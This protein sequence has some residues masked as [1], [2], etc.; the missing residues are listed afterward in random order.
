[1]LWAMPRPTVLGPLL[2]TA[3]AALLLVLVAGC[4]GADPEGDAP[5]PSASS[6]EAAGDLSGLAI[7]RTPFCESLPTAAITAALGGK[8]ADSTVYGNGDEV[9]VRP[10]RREVVHEV[11]CWFDAGG[12]RAWVWMFAPPV[13]DPEAERLVRRLDRP[14][15]EE[16]S[17]DGFGEPATALACLSGEEETVSYH[18]LFGDAW[19]GCSLTDPDS[20]PAELRRRAEMWC[21]AAARAAGGLPPRPA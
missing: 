7:E 20:G 11:G 16:L 12:A 2:G 14:G 4:T 21:F 9:E 15:C 8:A 17:A 5:S 3:P 1:M 13:P 19:L 18:G 6:P 10:G